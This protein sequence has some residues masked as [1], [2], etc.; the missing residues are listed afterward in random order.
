MGVFSIY[1]DSLTIIKEDD[2]IHAM[3]IGI[4]GNIGSG[5]DTVAEILIQEFSFHRISFASTLKDACASIFSWDRQALEGLN[6]ESRQWRESIDVWWA[7]RLDIPHLTPR[8]VLQN[9]GTDVMRK[10]FH[11]DI[12]I[13]SVERQ[14]N[15]TDGNIVIS[16]VRFLNEVLSIQSQDS[17]YIWRV[18][19]GGLPSWWDIAV[20]ASSGN[21]HSK[22]EL[23]RLGVHRSEWEWASTKPDEVINNNGTLEDL[24]IKV[25]R[26]ISR[27]TT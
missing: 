12:W 11:P 5:K 18:V 20:S 16:D 14:I 13:A 15:N 26:C 10:H 23:E 9:I 17:G 27:S 4:L 3:I 25:K 7:N 2:I 24:R 21:S 19:R 6:D 22:D 1:P 8:W